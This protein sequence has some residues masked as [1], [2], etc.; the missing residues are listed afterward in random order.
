[1]RGKGWLREI[2]SQF[3][4]LALIGAGLFWL[5]S[6]SGE[7]PAFAALKY[8]DTA[9]L[10]AF[11]LFGLMV[12]VF[13]FQLLTSIKLERFSPGNPESVK[14][15]SRIRRFRLPK[16]HARLQERWPGF[17]N[18][19]RDHLA[20]GRWTKSGLPP[21]DAVLTRARRLPA[22]GRTRLVDRVF[23]FYHPM[24]NVIIVDQALKESERQIEA[25]YGPLPAPRNRLVFVT[26]MQNR[27]E[28]TSAAAGVVNY[29][30]TVGHRTSL[31]PILVDLHAG[32]FF[33]P[34]DTTLLARRH[35]LYY[36]RK[37]HALRRWIVRGS[38]QRGS[39]SPESR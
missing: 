2:L 12:L 39:R 17:R 19:L 18:D 11:I 15:L 9:F 24:L 37:R 32:R 36:W 10:V 4:I 29:L 23:L 21:F 7:L 34:L 14:R 8:L 30:G 28:I 33:Y 31:Y 1:M 27:D 25:L 6:K 3:V 38:S 13:V 16:R 26:D 22:F 5:R 35:R 20:S